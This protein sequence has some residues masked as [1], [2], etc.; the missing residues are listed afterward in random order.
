MQLK[1]KEVGWLA[2]LGLATQG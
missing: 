1:Q 2:R